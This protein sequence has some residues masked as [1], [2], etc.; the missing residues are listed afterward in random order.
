MT[1]SIMWGRTASAVDQL[2]SLLKEHDYLG[3]PA[4]GKMWDRS[5]I[6]IATEFGRTKTRPAG[7]PSWGTGHDLNN[8]SVLISPLDQGQ[9]SLWRRRSQDRTDLR[10]RPRNR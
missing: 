2:I 4:L 5:L 6:Y 8:G 3:D 1:Q 9:P 7:S 10:L